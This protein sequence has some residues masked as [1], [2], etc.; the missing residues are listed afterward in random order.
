MSNKKLLVFHPTIAPYRIDYFNS[1]SQSF[2]SRIC[3]QYWNLKDQNFDYQ[4]IYNQ[5]LFKPI[6][7]NQS[8]KF[9]LLKD[10]YHQVKQFDPEIV[11]TSEFGFITLFVLLLRM[12]RR[13]KYKIAVMTD[14]SYDMI[15]KNNYFTLRHRVARKVIAP[16]VDELIVVEPRVEQWYKMKYG[17]G[18]YFPIIVDEIKA[19][20]YY[21]SLLPKSREL[22]NRFGL[23]GKKVLLSVCRLVDLKNL[24]RVIDAFSKITT[25]ATL[26]IVGDGPQR[27][28]LEKYAR[29]FDKDIIFT[30]RFDGDYLY[31]WYNVA[32][33]FILASYR[34]SFGAVTNESLIAGCH[35]IVSNRAGS[36]CL[37]DKS[38]GVLINPM[39]VA[40]ITKAIDEQLAVNPIPDLATSRKCLMTISFSKR[41]N[42]L[43]YLLESL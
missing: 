12:F 2:I 14:E 18:F 33:V 24:F 10:V 23:S 8:S 40:E 1:L 34:E 26:V 42:E 36:S 39:N 29:Q 16:F 11:L 15:E 4:R 32:T 31:S 9:L 30:G 27:N 22:I 25:D 5:F 28:D 41:I 35:V 37:V 43:I 38:N 21:R 3:L 13:F 6:Y 17:K 20:P 19:I 7:L